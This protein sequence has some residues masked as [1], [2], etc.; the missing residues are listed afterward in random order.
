MTTDNKITGS[1]LEVLGEGLVC[2]RTLQRLDLAGN[3]I[4]PAAH[5]TTLARLAA[6]LPKLTVVWCV[7]VLRWCGCCGVGDVT[8]VAMLLF[9]LLLMMLFMLLF[10]SHFTR[11]FARLGCLVASISRATQTYNNTNAHQLSFL[12]SSFPPFLLSSFPPLYVL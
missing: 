12:L 7:V 4:D 11:I 1:S 8:V 9:T 10:L 2:G 3:A 5:H 6:S